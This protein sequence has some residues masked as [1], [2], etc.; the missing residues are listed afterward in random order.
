MR[1]DLFSLIDRN[2]DGQITR[3]EMAAA[4][5]AKWGEQRHSSSRHAKKSDFGHSFLASSC[6]VDAVLHVE[7]R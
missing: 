5:R 1:T 7:Q 2:H 6:S 4:F 3:A